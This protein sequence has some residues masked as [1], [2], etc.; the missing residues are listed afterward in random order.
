MNITV[1][2]T[3][4]TGLDHNKQ[5]VIQVAAISYVIGSDGEAYVKKKFE[6]K[7]LP[8]HIETAEAK[9]L[10][11]NKYNP[12]KWKAE[13][14]PRAVVLHFLKK[15]L[16]EAD[17]LLGQNLIFDLRFLHSTYKKFGTEPPEFPPYIDTKQLAQNVK[18]RK[19]ITSTSM[20]YLC[21]HYNIEFTGNAH[22]AL[23]D[24]ERTMSVF[25]LFQEKGEE[26]E[27]YSFTNPYERR[28][29]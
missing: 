22:D 6:A 4:T 14:K 9:A 2:D 11:I 15:M 20:D 10:E 25:N 23:T 26:Y 18:N 19:E 16:E 28:R 5:E 24:C 1:L 7:L 12:E 3:E 29:Y 21:E 13:A 17:L 27:V 8:Q